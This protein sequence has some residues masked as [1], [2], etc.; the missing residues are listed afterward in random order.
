MKCRTS[1]VTN[2]S[3]SSFILAFKDEKDLEVFEENCE[4]SDY[5]EFYK[6]IENLSSDFLV[7]DNDTKEEMPIRPLIKKIEHIW[8]NEN[9]SFELSKLYTEDYKIK[10][11]GSV[12]IKINNFGD[13]VL[14]LEELNFEEI[15]E[16]DKYSIRI[17]SNKA[18]RDKN[19]ALDFLYHCYSFDFKYKILD[20]NFKHCYPGDDT[21]KQKQEY[22]ESDELKLL[23]EDYLKNNEEYQEKKKQIE[24]SE[25]IVKGMIWDTS[26]GLLEW[27]IRNGFIEDNFRRNCVICYNVG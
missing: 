4:W 25:I 18:N 19:A 22:E 16:K 8:W 3:S 12:S 2:S 21:W 14:D 17:L 27:A 10:P 26:G 20:E 23:V 13:N 5:D 11:Y 24:D 9:I 6:L 7:F 15:Y 1:F